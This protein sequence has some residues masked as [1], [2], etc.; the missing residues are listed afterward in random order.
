MC[1]GLVGVRFASVFLAFLEVFLGDF[2]FF[3]ADAAVAVLVH[4][5]LSGD[6]ILNSLSVEVAG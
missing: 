6:T 4:E 3:G 5:V 1:W 2:G